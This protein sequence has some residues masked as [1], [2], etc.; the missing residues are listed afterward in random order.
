MNIKTNFIDFRNEHRICLI[1]GSLDEL[2]GMIADTDYNDFD[3]CSPSPNATPRTMYK[4]IL[5]PVCMFSG[6]Y[7]EEG[8]LPDVFA[9][10]GDVISHCQLLEYLLSNIF[11]RTAEATSLMNNLDR[12]GL[13]VEEPKTVDITLYLEKIKGGYNVSSDWHSFS[14]EPMTY[15]FY[16][17]NPKGI[18]LY[19]GEN[20]EVF[21]FHELANSIGKIIYAL[22]EYFKRDVEIV[23]V[24]EVIIPHSSEGHE[25]DLPKGYSQFLRLVNIAAEKER[26]YREWLNEKYGNLRSH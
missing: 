23:H 19:V 22:R 6:G 20:E 3:K 8:E 9:R 11:Y 12:F 26:R 4:L 2:V 17:D 10:R 7:W 16:S 14:G 13:K 24:C 25:V 15:I 5:D 21:S 18:N 1:E